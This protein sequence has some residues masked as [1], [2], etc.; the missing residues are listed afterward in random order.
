MNP[1]PATPAGRAGDAPLDPA[2]IIRDAL[3]ARNR[4]R[5]DLAVPI[6]REALRIHPSNAPLWQVLGLMHRALEDSPSAI[7]AFREAARLAPADPTIA[8]GHAR[9]CMEG[10]RPAVALFDR[11]RQLAPDNGDIIIGRAAAQAAEG[12]P[13]R[14]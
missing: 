13:W 4:G 11:A 1:N 10:G 12:G 6:L 14:R 9:V 2:T 8:H 3:G 5:A 7:Q